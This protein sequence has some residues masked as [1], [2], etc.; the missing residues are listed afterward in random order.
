MDVI[1]LIRLAFVTATIIIAILLVI[2]LLSIKKGNKKANLFLIASV[3][4]ITS[5]SFSSLLM[6]S[7]AYK[8]IPTLVLINYPFVFIL[9]AIY[10]FYIQLLINNEFKF[11]AYHILHAIP[12]VWAFYQI[13]WFFPFSF[14]QKVNI[15]TQLWFGDYQLNFKDFILYSVPNFITIIYL[16]ISFFLI[17][18]SAKKLKVNFSNTDIEYFFWLKKFTIIY[19]FLVLVDSIRL[20]LSVRFGWDP[21]EGEIVTNLLVSGLVQFYI[22]QTIKNP[23]R[24][25]YKLTTTKNIKTAD[26]I[27]MHT[28]K[29]L[30]NL[31]SDFLTKLS[32]FMKEE[33]PYLNPE[34][35]SHELAIM[36][37]VTPHYL[38]KKINQEFNVN[39]YN[40]VNQYRVEEFKKKALKNENKNL[41]LTAIAQNVGFNSKSSFNRIFKSLTL[42][43]P[44]EYL[45]QHTPH[46]PT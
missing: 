2:V 40:F 6:F 1:N 21:G 35:K 10:Y 36:L 18:N 8:F 19:I 43:T 30:I 11:K 29:H 41:T 32:T 15:L 26:K 14:D 33:K 39:F 4:I 25:F 42:I 27:K 38:S 20:G 9:G 17:S 22:F 23:E 37:G 7:G 34:L 44:T 3:L 12:L 28:D 24:V 46:K 16:I 13:K 31:D 5:G 45:K